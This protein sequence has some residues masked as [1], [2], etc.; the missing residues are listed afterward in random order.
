MKSS[1]PLTIALSLTLAVASVLAADTKKKPAP[2][3][4]PPAEAKPEAAKPEGKAEV[5][6]AAKAAPL[7]ET[8]AVVEGVPIKKEELETAFQNV[9]RAQRIPADQIPAEERAMGY[10]MILDELIIDRLIIKRSADTLVT[11]EEVAAQFERIKTQF[12]SEEELKKALAEAGETVD[13]VKQGMRARLRQEHWMEQ[14]IKGKTE[15]TDADAKDFYDKN[16]EQ[17]KSPEQVRASHI[18]ISVEE[19]AKPEV[20]AQKKKTAEEI[21]ARVKKGEAFDKLAKELSED[22]SAKENSGDLDFFSKDQMVPEFSQAAFGMKKDEI[23]A[24]VR[25]KFGY[26]VIKLT[27]RKGAETVPL[28]KAKPQLVAY[29]QRQKKQTEIE[30]VVQ[31]IRSKADVKVNLP[32]PPAQAPA[33]APGAAP[34]P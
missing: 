12:G 17:F 23:S 6:P 31:E 24:P 28:E 7:P 2:K 29:L 34:K 21:A 4:P 5:A 11:D 33:L 13:K 32:E 22:P 27:D 10:R 9:L 1:G 14:Q 30:K 25:S 18:L 26:H 15:V 16:I 8:V 3:G 20:D 19:G